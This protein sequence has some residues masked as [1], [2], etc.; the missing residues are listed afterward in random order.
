VPAPVAL[1]LPGMTLNATIFPPLDLPTIPVDFNTLAL[2][3]DGSTPALLA[4]R[5][6]LYVDLLDRRLEGQPAWNNPRRIIVAHSFGGMLALTWWLQ[7]GGKGVAKVD[8]MVLV[9][10][11]AGPMFE[12]VRVRVAGTGGREIRIGLKPFIRLWNRP[13]LTRLVKRLLTRG[14]LEARSVDFRSL[15]HPS[16]WAIDFAG[17]RNT[18]WRA[19]RS[20]RFALEGF[21][22]RDRLKE[23]DCPVIV[24]HG[25]ADTLLPLEWGRQLA[26]GLPRAELRVVDGAG[27]VLPLTHGAEVVKAVK[28][29]SGER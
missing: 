26:A 16:D 27:H 2:G 6:G 14:S 15:R 1:L 5:M 19:M 8:G 9:A 7:H 24:L 13:G 23:L 25:N 29:V 11:T 18:D 28:E 20:Y 3:S 22:V 12:A 4:R 17:W 10:T 21:D